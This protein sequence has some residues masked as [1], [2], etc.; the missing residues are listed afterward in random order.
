MKRRTL[1][2]WLLCVA[3]CTLTG[4]E[5]SEE[6]QDWTLS[7]ETLS[8]LKPMTVQEET[9]ARLTTGK[10]YREWVYACS[11]SLGMLCIWNNKNE[12]DNDVVTGE[13]FYGRPNL[14]PLFEFTGKRIVRYQH[15]AA[16][17]LSDGYSPCWGCWYF[18]DVNGTL[19]FQP[20]PIEHRADIKGQMT[21]MVLADDYIVF[22]VFYQF[23]QNAYHALIVF[24]AVSE[25]TARNGWNLNQPMD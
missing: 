11:D 12:L 1:C 24:E 17:S 14:N 16:T 4:C 3:V 5:P 9:F 21:L 15:I 23:V 18:N 20:Y 25:E 10:R 13:Q 7:Y 6:S 19:A 8:T 22:R 2:Y